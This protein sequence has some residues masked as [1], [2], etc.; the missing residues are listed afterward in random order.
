MKAK[1]NSTKRLVEASVMVAFATVLSMLKLIDLPYGGSV[2]AA[3]MLPIVIIAYRHGTGAGLLSGLVYAT[4]Q[5]LLGLNTL[6][7]VTGWQSMVAVIMLDYILAFTLIGFGGIFKGK[8]SRVS[9]NAGTRQSAELVFGLVFVCIFRYVCHTVAG[10]TVWAGLSIPTEAALIYS[11]GYN[12]TYMIPET[13]VTSLVAAWLGSVLDLSKA[14]PTRFVTPT[15]ASADRGG[16]CEVLPRFITL[17]AIITVA[18]DT[19]LLAPYF[20]NSES[21]ALDFSGLGSAPW[22]AVAIITALGT[23]TLAVL[24]VLKVRAKKRS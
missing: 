15:S 1:K 20:Q 6:S 18:I 16:A 14:T 5:Q 2:T 3:S 10:A 21:G 12:A 24:L 7:Y 17:I 11:V 9:G 4:I 8:L 22:L 13:I 23:I 19:L